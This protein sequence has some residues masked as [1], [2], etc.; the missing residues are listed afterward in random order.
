MATTVYAG[1][2]GLGTYGSSRYGAIS[3]THSPDGLQANVVSNSGVNIIGDARHVVVSLVSPAVEGSV[4]IIGVANVSVTGSSVTSTLNPTLSFILDQ[5]LDVNGYA[6]S[7]SLGGLVVSAD[8]NYQIISGDSISVVGDFTD[9]YVFA[10]A[11]DE[12]IGQIINVLGNDNVEFILDCKPRI[13]SPECLGSIGAVVVTADSVTQPLGVQASFSVSSLQAFGDSNTALV[14]VQV[15]S[16]LGTSS[17]RSENTIAVS[18]VESVSYVNDNLNIIGLANHTMV[19]IAFTTQ[20]G[21]L[22]VTADSNTAITG[23]GI[24]SFLGDVA[25]SDNARPTF[26]SLSGFVSISSVTVSTTYFDYNAVADAYARLRTVIINPG[27]TLGQ[28]RVIVEQQPRTIAIARSSTTS[29][30]SAQ[31]G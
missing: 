5:I 8:S 30:R 14:G 29:D 18:G 9:I 17:V 22:L 26:D 1:G 2:Y 25:V 7:S 12:P 27:A 15:S 19:G 20:I 23:N 11:L 13:T 31:V 6:V 28:R 16:T 24:S 21:S 3:V 4:G 10:S